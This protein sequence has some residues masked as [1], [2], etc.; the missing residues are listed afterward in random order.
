MALAWKAVTETLGIAASDQGYF[1]W[2]K[3]STTYA[4]LYRLNI[5]EENGIAGLIEIR[6]ADGET[7]VADAKQL[8]NYM[9]GL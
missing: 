3:D 2:L 7:C 1:Y 8:A 4:T 6:K 5:D 9:E